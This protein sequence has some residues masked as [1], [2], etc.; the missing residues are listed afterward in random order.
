MKRAKSIELRA[1]NLGD[2]AIGVVQKY[3]KL[4]ALRPKLY[5]HGFTLIE[6]SIVIFIM[7]IMTSVTVPWMKS[8][9]E[10]TKLRSAARS[11]V[12]LMEFARNS[13]ITQRTDYVVLFDPANRE[14]WLSLKELLEEGTGSSVTDSSRT[15][16]SESL[17]A[18]STSESEGTSEENEEDTESSISRAGGILGIPKQLP[19]GINIARLSS[20]RSSGRDT[21]GVDYVTFYL[22]GT[23]ED[24]EIYLQSS[25]GRVYHLAV[26]EATGR[27]GV[28]ELRSEEIEEIGLE[29]SK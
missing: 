29:I 1:K 9:A 4:C 2:R 18:L 12:S 27:A 3:Y 21:S 24:F 20:S 10:S 19:N 17:E 5:A 22:N 26:T 16:L 11:V 7:L 14:Y 23:A 6:V 25:T 13:A 8:F 28:R 15:S